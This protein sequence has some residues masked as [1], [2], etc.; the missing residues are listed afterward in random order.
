M[1]P[2]TRFRSALGRLSHSH[3]SHVRPTPGHKKRGGRPRQIERLEERCLL[4]GSPPI[5]EFP[6]PN[7]GAGRSYQAVTGRDGNLWFSLS[8]N[9]PS[10]VDSIGRLNTATGAITEFAL[11]TLGDETW[12]I[13]SGPDGNIWFTD[14]NPYTGAESIGTINLTTHV[15]TQYP[16]SS[17]S[18]VLRGITTGPDGN[19][20]FTDPGSSSIGTITPTGQITEY[21]VPNG[22]ISVG[23]ATGSDGNVWFASISGSMVGSINPTT[24]V[25]SEFATPTPNSSPELITAGPDGNL[26][27]GEVTANQIGEINPVTDAI[28]EY[29]VPTANSSPLG[30]TAGPDGNVW[31]IEH[32]LGR[33]GKIN[34]TS[35]AVSEYAIPD[36]FQSNTPVPIGITTGPDGNLWFSDEASNAIGKVNITTPQL[37]MTQQ[38]PSGVTAGTTFGLSVQ[39]V[40][41][42]G[43]VLSSFN[44]PVTI[45]LSNNPAGGT[46]GGTLTVM[47]SGGVARFSSVSLNKA[48][49]DTLLVSAGGIASVAT[50]DINVTPAA[51]TQVAITQQPPASVAVNAGFGLTVAVEDQYGNVVTS[52]INT[53]KVALANNPTGAETRRHALPEDEQWPGHV[54]GPDTQQGG[55]RL[56]ARAIQ[57]RPDRRDHQCRQCDVGS[58]GVEGIGNVRR[59]T[60]HSPGPC[61]VGS[62]PRAGFSALRRTSAL[63]Y[64]TGEEANPRLMK[65]PRRLGPPPPPVVPRRWPPFPRCR[66][67]AGASLFGRVFRPHDPLPA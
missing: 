19:L 6:L 59:R 22:T 48:A 52:V 40:D 57:Q 38:P 23:I 10:G 26:W 45:A 64:R 43:N 65:S 14:S 18:H 29:P 13:T 16:L 3:T 42:S 47:A 17:T 2:V 27:F 41:T 9:G 56:H 28:T 49:H 35:H 54:L 25:I 32:N 61:C 50:S 66:P 60:T 24:H 4:S 5:S 53:V 62:R 36:Y 34:P 63:R 37:L 55:V 31:F 1:T 20:W 12:A 67:R 7:P 46:L 11:S 30:I 58:D 39:A 21:A 8:S 33:I 15:I 44:G 51:A